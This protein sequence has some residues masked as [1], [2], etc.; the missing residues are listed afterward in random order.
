ML[1]QFG[2]QERSKL[3]TEVKVERGERPMQALKATSEKEAGQETNFLSS[4]AA[5]RQ[6]AQTLFELSQDLGAS[7]SLGE[8]LS[9]FSVKIKRLVPYDAIAMYVRRGEELIPEHVSGDNFRLFASLR[10][11]IGQG[12]SGWVAQNKKPIINGNPSVEPG[13]LNDPTKFSTLRSALSIPLEGL[14]GVVGRAHALQARTRCVHLR[15]PAHSAGH[16][17]KDGAGH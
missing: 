17:L 14:A 1:Q 16:H 3:S 7:L 10:I 11:P 13:Y 4:I 2:R 9:V 12:L 15:P 6:E 5:A 8:T